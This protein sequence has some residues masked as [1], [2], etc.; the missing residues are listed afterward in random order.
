MITLGLTNGQTFTGAVTPIIYGTTDPG[1][2]V[3]IN[4]N[5]L[6]AITLGPVTA[7]SYGNWSIATTSALPSGIYPF[8][9]TVT[10]TDGTVKI[11]DPFE[12]VVA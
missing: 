2:V 6:G 9:A 7:D 11:S 3:V 1:A 12:L 4:Y 5:S 10:G 8:V